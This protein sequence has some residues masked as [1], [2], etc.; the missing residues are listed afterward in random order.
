MKFEIDLGIKPNKLTPNGRIYPKDVLDKAI[1]EAVARKLP[2]SFGYSDTSTISMKS[3]AGY[4]TDYNDDTCKVTVEIVDTPMGRLANKMLTQQFEC[5]F[6]FVAT[7][8]LDGNNV[9]TMHPLYGCL[10]EKKS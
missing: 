7:G 6:S 3:I 1:K 2:V 8:T 5:S 9:T 4:V 10:I